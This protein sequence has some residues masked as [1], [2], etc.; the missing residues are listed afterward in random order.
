MSLIEPSLNQKFF[1][2]SRVNECLVGRKDNKQK[3][4]L[5][6]TAKLGTNSELNKLIVPVG[7]NKVERPSFLSP[8]KDLDA[9]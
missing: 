8:L 2:E 7:E 4:S 1:K 9:I 6:E 3:G 5:A